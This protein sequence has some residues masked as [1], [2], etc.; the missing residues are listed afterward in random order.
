[1]NHAA[2]RWADSY[3]AGTGE[4]GYIT[5]RPDDPDI[6]TVAAEHGVYRTQDGGETWMPAAS[7]RATFAGFARANASPR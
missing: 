3:V 4:S 1:M 6:V 5:V 7:S 2:I